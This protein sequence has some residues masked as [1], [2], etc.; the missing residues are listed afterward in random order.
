MLKVSHITMTNKQRY[1]LTDV[2]F[3]LPA[4]GFCAITAK[5]KETEKAISYLL[6]GMKQA[7]AGFLQCDETKVTK[8]PVSHKLCD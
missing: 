6:A 5:E 4:H 3:V 8:K 2:S 7:D 1:L